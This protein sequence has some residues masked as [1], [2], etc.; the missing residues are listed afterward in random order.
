M[1]EAKIKGRSFVLDEKLWVVDLDSEGIGAQ[2]GIT[3]GMR[4][5]GFQVRCKFCLLCIS[6]SCLA[7]IYRV[8]YIFNAG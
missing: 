2:L 3:L 5:I 4:L 1:E 6:S 8:Y 7:L